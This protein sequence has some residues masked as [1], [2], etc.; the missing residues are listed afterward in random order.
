MSVINTRHQKREIPLIDWALSYSLIYA[1][2][3]KMRQ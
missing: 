2:V 1:E 3:G